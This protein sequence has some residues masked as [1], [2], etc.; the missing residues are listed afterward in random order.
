[1][2]WDVINHYAY[3]HDLREQYPKAEPE[4]VELLNEMRIAAANYNKLTGRTSRM[5]GEIGE[6]Y[7]AIITGAK[8]HYNDTA[9]G[10]DA[11][12]GNDWIEVKTITP[13]KNSNYV[14]VK[15]RG[16]FNKVYVVKVHADYSLSGRMFDRKEVTSGKPKGTKKLRIRWDT[17]GGDGQIR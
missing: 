8:L 1:M 10:S 11:R 2:S 12:L 15:C 7:C 3:L 16:N 17:I 4:Q 13:A 9:Q 6:L 14:D 5:L